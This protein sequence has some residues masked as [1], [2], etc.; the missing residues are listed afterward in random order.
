MEQRSEGLR[1]SAASTIAARLSHTHAACPYLVIVAIRFEMDYT[2][3]PILCIRYGLALI[4]QVQ[5]VGSY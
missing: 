4:R 5:S 2:V 1:A 3:I